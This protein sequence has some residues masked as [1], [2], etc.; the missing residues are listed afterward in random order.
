MKGERAL[1]DMQEGGRVKDLTQGSSQ[2]WIFTLSLRE[3]FKASS[4]RTE[5]AARFQRQGK[6][7]SQ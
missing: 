2:A 7:S 4:I 1:R 3:S 5:I 6:I